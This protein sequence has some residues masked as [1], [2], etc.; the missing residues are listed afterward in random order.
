MMSTSGYAR[1]TMTGGVIR[2]NRA[3]GQVWPV[4]YASSAIQ[5]FGG[6][7]FIPGN[8]YNKNE[9]YMRGG[10]ITDNR[11]AGT[12]GSGIVMDMIASTAPIFSLGASA[13]ITGNDVH[14]HYND[15]YQFCFITIESSLNAANPGEIVITMDANAAGSNIKVLGETASGLVSA[16]YAKFTAPPYTIGSNG[17]LN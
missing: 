4:L 5:G 16:N 13:V 11:S 10:A 7:I 6:G 12:A 2:N 8:T 15:Y 9:F 3:S 17:R 1:L 14:L